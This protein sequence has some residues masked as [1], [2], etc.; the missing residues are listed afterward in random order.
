MGGGW[1][2]RSHS[3]IRVRV[4]VSEVYSSSLGHHFLRRGSTTATTILLT[5]QSF[6]T[7]RLLGSI[8]LLCSHKCSV[9]RSK[10]FTNDSRLRYGPGYD[11]PLLLLV[12]HWTDGSYLCLL[13]YPVL[14]Y[15]PTLRPVPHFVRSPAPRVRSSLPLPPIPFRPFR[16]SSPL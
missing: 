9:K 5:T 6:P 4:P 10:T 13:L 8:D 2:G 1:G 15:T 16:E 7:G 3:G 12:L 11:R 14:S